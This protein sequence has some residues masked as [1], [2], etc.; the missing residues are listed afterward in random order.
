MPTD[1]SATSNAPLEGEFSDFD[2]NNNPYLESGLTGL[3]RHTGY[4]DEEFLPQLS[5]Y[6]AIQMY[7]E[8]RDNDPVIGAILYA[9]D[10]L[11][12]GVTWR[13]DPY[14]KD[15]KD[16]EM[17][18]FVDECLHDMSTSWEDLISEILSMLVY[19]WSF[20]EVVYKI[21]K[22]PKQKNPKLRSKFD[23]GKI[24]WRKMPI[25]AQ[26][27]KLDWIFDVKGGIKGMRQSA[28][29]TY[30]RID[31]GIEKALLFRT[32]THKN[33]PEGRSILRNAYRSYHVKK[34]MEEIEAIG[35]E[36]DL[37]GFPVIYVDPAIMRDTATAAQKA[38]FE[39]YQMMITNIRRDEQEGVVMPSVYDDQGH[40]I[41][42]LE[43]LSSGGSRDFDTNSIITR[44]DQRIATSVLAD[45]ILLGQQT[46][47]SFAMSADK[48][49][50]FATTLWSYLTSI[51]SVFNNHAIP[52]LFNLNNFDMT[53]LPKLVPGD[54]ETPDL[55]ALGNYI[56]VLA[57][58]GVPLF[59]DNALE[60]YLR[61]A[62][63]LPLR[64]EQGANPNDAQPVANPAGGNANPA[65]NGASA[66]PQPPVSIPAKAVASAAKK[67]PT[68]TALGAK[69]TKTQNTKAP[70]V[71]APFSAAPLRKNARKGD[72]Y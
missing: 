52:R 55:G 34:R 15:K 45:F 26:E 46:H 30:E 20:H 1:S 31:I 50:M 71:P 22:G 51:A 5:G 36:R 58:A 25:R 23:D 67:K 32:L 72:A 48:T 70:T 54:I 27:S 19:G 8:M 41:Y 40:Q 57:G 69:T 61:E 65:T 60:S 24:G 63:G 7:R 28:P 59:P 38:V 47:G 3:R 37:A 10:K 35:V 33:N 53:R 17:A 6:R 12:R 42:K 49:D 14:S 68:K 62:A 21:R 9:I 39:D 18:A 16:E 2:P 66:A 11:L 44:Y 43:L 64:E 4:V 13:V 56:Q 29:P